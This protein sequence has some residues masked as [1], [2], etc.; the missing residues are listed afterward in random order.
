MYRLY[1]LD[2]QGLCD[3]RDMAELRCRK[4]LGEKEERPNGEVD[5]QHTANSGNYTTPSTHKQY[6]FKTC[7]WLLHYEHE[8]KSHDDKLKRLHLSL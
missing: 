3:L 7:V 6:L 8:Y 1:Q 5:W 2:Q 4:V